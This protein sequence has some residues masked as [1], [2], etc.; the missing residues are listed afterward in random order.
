MDT[1]V[2]KQIAAATFMILL[3]SWTLE[4]EATSS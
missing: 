4:I 2:L 1:N 3:V